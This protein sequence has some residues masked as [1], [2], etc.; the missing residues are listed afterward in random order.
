MHC[1]RCHG[2]IVIEKEY[3]PAIARWFTECRCV[4]CGYRVD[5]TRQVNRLLGQAEKTI[6]RKTTG[7][8]PPVLMVH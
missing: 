2:L 8:T 6:E 4:N 5:Q 3:D 1:Q 7:P